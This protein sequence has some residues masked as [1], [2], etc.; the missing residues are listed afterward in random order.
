MKRKRG[1]NKE[2]RKEMTDKGK[3]HTT[4]DDQREEN[5]LKERKEQS[6]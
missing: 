5:D 3:V 6:E 2:E 1:G 4:Q